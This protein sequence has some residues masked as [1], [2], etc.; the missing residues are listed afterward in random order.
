M[1]DTPIVI[2]K[3][4]V[5]VDTNAD[6][7]PTKGDIP[8]LTN[9]DVYNSAM[10][11]VDDLCISP[12]KG[13]ASCVSDISPTKGDASCVYVANYCVLDALHVSDVPALTNAEVYNSVDV[14]NSA[15]IS[16]HDS[17]VPLTKGDASC[18]SFADYCVLGMDLVPPYFRPHFCDCTFSAGEGLVVVSLLS[19]SAPQAET[20]A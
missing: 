6:V 3:F 18:V 12:T 1:C 2:R 16:V 7:N 9:A 17:Y 14:Y 11:L 10:V 4:D 20:D 13:D 15:V 19:V 5:I 8:T